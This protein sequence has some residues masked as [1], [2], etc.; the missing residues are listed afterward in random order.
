MH[1]I[2]FIVLLGKLRL[3]KIKFFGHGTQT[4]HQAETKYKLAVSTY[5]TGKLFSLL[6]WLGENNEELNTIHKILCSRGEEVKHST[7]MKIMLIRLSLAH[8]MIIHSALT[9]LGFITK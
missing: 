7:E 8:D 2:N 1:S 9:T 4:N 6:C 5:T 3:R